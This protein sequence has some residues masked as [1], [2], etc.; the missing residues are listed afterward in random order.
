[1]PDVSRTE[2]AS[3]SETMPTLLFAYGTLSPGSPAAA[4]HAG[5]EPDSVR[6]RLFDLG[7]YPALVDCGDPAAGW[8]H[9][10][11]RPVDVDDLQG[12]LDSYEGVSDGLYRRVEALSKA[13]RRVWVY[14][15]SRPIPS[16][17]RGPLEQW[18]GRRT[19][20]SF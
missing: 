14:V 2:V 9:G 15:Y 4:A 1:M 19:G 20:L 5:W 11:V 10:Y 18:E 16:E 7:A 6:G 12:R 3:S 8:V 17:A 13:R